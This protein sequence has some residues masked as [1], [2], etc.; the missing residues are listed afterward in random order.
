MLKLT[1]SF[2]KNK[3]NL[4]Y[5]THIEGGC[6][7]DHPFKNFEGCVDY[8]LSSLSSVAVEISS[9]EGENYITKEQENALRKVVEVH[10]KLKNI[11]KILKE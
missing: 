4:Y 9:T 7:V 3:D 10:N 2:N 5:I 8:I 11:E 6:Y 1:L